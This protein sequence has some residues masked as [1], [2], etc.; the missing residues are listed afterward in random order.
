[1]KSVGYD[2]RIYSNTRVRYIKLGEHGMWEKECVEKNVIRYGYGSGGREMFSLC[3]KRRWPEV[4]KCYIGWGKDKGTATRFTNETRLFFEADATTLWIT[5]IGER[6]YW[7]MLDSSVPKPCGDK[8]SVVRKVARGWRET[9]L[10]GKSLT[11]D[12]LSGALTKLSAYRG[13][14]CNVDV[15]EY[16]IRRINGETMPEVERAVQASMEMKSA[17]LKLITLLHPRDFEMLVD[18]VFSTSG[19]QRQGIVGKTQKTL[20]IDIMLPSTGERAFVQIKSKTTSAELTE[21]VGKIDQL[22]PFDRMFYVYHSGEAKTDDD[23]VI[24]I[25][26][27]KL[28]ELVRDAG[29]TTWLIRKVS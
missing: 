8:N 22:G 15:A 26:P 17:V 2:S 19:W 9:D 28:A 3:M 21:Y 25:G 5:F 12:R 16:V 6:L 29:L 24:V 7:G 10:K 23:R 4:K 18:L 13:T 27:E 1:M 20:D 11:K 14:S